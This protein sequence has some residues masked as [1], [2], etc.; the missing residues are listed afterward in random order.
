LTG[1]QKQ[2]LQRPQTQNAAASLLYLKGRFHW[3]KR[4]EVG[5]QKAV[6]CLEEALRID[7]EY[8]LA[9]AG[10][11]DSYNLPHLAPWSLEEAGP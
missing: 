11:A 6:Q 2:R 1:E 7:P 8:A 10:L 4:T 3:N 5:L 9:H